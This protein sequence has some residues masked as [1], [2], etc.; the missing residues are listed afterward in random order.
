MTKKKFEPSYGAHQAKR[1][2]FK[3]K[4]SSLLAGSTPPS[5]ENMLCFIDDRSADSIRALFGIRERKN[6]GAILDMVQTCQVIQQASPTRCILD[7]LQRG[8]ARWYERTPSPSSAHL[9]AGSWVNF[10]LVHCFVIQMHSN[11]L[12]FFSL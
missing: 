2:A 8:Y 7:C 9:N 1:S 12:F 5:Q 6:Y 4:S 3:D 10:A 11:A